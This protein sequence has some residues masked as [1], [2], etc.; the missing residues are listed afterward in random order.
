MIDQKT[1]FIL[2]A[3][4]SKPYGY[5]TGDELRDYICQRFH[6]ITQN[7]SYIDF[8]NFNGNIKEEAKKLSSTFFKS[9]TKSIDL[10]ISRRNDFSQIGKVAIAC[11]ILEAEK[12]SKF[13]ELSFSRDQDWYSYLYDR[14]T[15]RLTKHSHYKDFKKNNVSFI[16]FNYDRSFEY[17]LFES[18]AY[19]FDFKYDIN[20]LKDQQ[21]EENYTYKQLIPFEIIHVYGKIAHLPGEENDDNKKELEYQATQNVAKKIDVMNFTDNIRVIFERTDEDINKI[22]ELIKN[23]EQIFFLGFG[24]ADENLEVLDIPDILNE[25]QTIY[26]TAYNYTEREID[27]ILF[28]FSQNKKLEP[29]IRERLKVYI[30][31]KDSLELLKKYL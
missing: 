3:G 21:S 17:F 7:N 26:G 9:S 6:G 27:D 31:N 14:M 25:K 4:A 5:P 20:F 1:V 23:A 13:R 22:K 15:K 2:G 16:S 18:F 11:N 8:S 19:S 29:Y 24:F 10:F 28:M 12:K 30:E